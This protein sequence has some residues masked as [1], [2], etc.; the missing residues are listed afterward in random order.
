MKSIWKRVTAFVLASAMALAVPLSSFADGSL[1][2]NANSGGGVAA[3]ND[4]NYAAKFHTYPQ[5]QGICL[6]IVV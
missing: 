1:A 5:N 4:P 3:G 6:S 2:V